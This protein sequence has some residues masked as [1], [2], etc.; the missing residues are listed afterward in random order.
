MFGLGIQELLIIGLILLIP[1]GIIGAIV[2][3]FVVASGRKTHMSNPN[4]TP[5]LDCG[6]LLSPRA[7]TC[8]K[9]GC[10]VVGN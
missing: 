4:L 8:P 6:N 7:T 1:I 9:C 3:V 5:C 2:V 10:H